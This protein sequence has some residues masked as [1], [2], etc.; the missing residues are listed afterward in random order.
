MIDLNLDVVRNRFSICMQFALIY[1]GMINLLFHQTDYSFFLVFLCF[2]SSDTKSSIYY[3]LISVIGMCYSISLHITDTR[4]IDMTTYKFLICISN[5]YDLWNYKNNNKSQQLSKY[6][7]KLFISMNVMHAVW[8][9]LI[10]NLSWE[11]QTITNF[12]S[13]ELTNMDFNQLS[14]AVNLIIRDMRI[15]FWTSCGSI[16]ATCI[17]VIYL[18]FSYNKQMYDKIIQNLESSREILSKYPLWNWF[19]SEYV[20]GCLFYFAFILCIT[21][22]VMFLSINTFINSVFLTTVGI[23]IAQLI[24]SKTIYYILF[25]IVVCSDDEI[26]HKKVFNFLDFLTSLPNIRLQIAINKFVFDSIGYLI[27]I[28]FINSNYNSGYMSVLRHRLT[29]INENNSEIIPDPIE[30]T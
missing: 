5:I 17:L 15:S 6:P 12:V 23:Y 7:L 30:A 20:S 28:L 4:I 25:N 2:I 19:I 24:I 22:T 14:D 8:S 27:D 26:F 1:T 16:Y 21:S 29:Q 13:D 3:I 18:N 10:I 9:S 11:F